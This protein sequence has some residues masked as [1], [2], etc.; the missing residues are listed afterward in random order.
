MAANLACGYTDAVVHHLEIEMIVGNSQIH[1]D[2]AR[3]CVARNVR[4]D[5]L[6]Y[7]EYGCGQFPV[8]NYLVLGQI[9]PATHSHALLELLRLP[10]ECRYQSHFIKNLRPQAGRNSANEMHRGIDEAAH[11]FGFLHKLLLGSVQLPGQP[12]HIHLQTGQHLSQLVVDF[13]C[14][15]RALFFAYGNQARGQRPQL[16]L[17]LAQPGLRV[18]SLFDFVCECRVLLVKF[19]ENRHFRSQHLRHQ[20][21]YQVIHRAQFVSAKR[22]LQIRLHGGQKNDR[23]VAGLFAQADYPGGFEAV[24]SRHAHVQKNHRQVVLEYRA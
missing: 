24:H 5:F 11:G 14:N 17:R 7:P 4:Q 15:P 2:A 22:G 1:F 21:L 3:L 20:R 8:Q 18:R 12:G 19:D 16:H 9:E 23:R 13:A 6:K 10:A